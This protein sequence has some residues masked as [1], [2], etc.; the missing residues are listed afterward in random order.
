MPQYLLDY[1]DCGYQIANIHDDATRK[2]S[3]LLIFVEDGHFNLKTSRNEIYI[4]SFK[5]SMT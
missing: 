5:R 2:Y 1:V 3:S 4:N